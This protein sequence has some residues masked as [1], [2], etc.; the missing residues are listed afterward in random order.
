MSGQKN[1][2]A[3]SR[4]L[5]WIL[6]FMLAGTLAVT[7]M[8]AGA[9]T[10]LSSEDLH[11]RASVSDSVVREQKE[12][13]DARIRELAEEYAFSTD[14]VTGTITE[15]TIREL[16]QEYARWWTRIVNEGV[17][18]DV[19]EWSSAE[20]ENAI[21]E[22]MEAA[23][24]NAA[25]RAGEAAGAIEKTI[26]ETLMP[27]RKALITLGLKFIRKRIDLPSAIRLLGQLPLAGAAFCLALAGLIALLTAR[28][29]RLGLKY[30][31]TAAAG[32]GLSVIAGFI[33]VSLLGIP[34]MIL[35][36]SVVLGHQ[37]DI[38]IRP[39]ATGCVLFAAV[40]I[41]GGFLLLYLYR[42]GKPKARR[43]EAAA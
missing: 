19:P 42:N 32:A 21:A 28:K 9:G 23:G 24:E 8:S 26:H 20:L 40:L 25:E 22:N 35:E 13:I 6:A 15:E 14:A 29:T 31:G 16:D 30:F 10:A 18:G 33:M 7:I 3:L 11:V 34:K 41:A 39:V 36:S 12:K 27:V 2:C 38:L 4:A 43:A 17:I 1:P 5:A 37:A